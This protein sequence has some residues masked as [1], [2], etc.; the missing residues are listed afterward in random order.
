M[1]PRRAGEQESTQSDRRLHARQSPAQDRLSSIRARDASRAAG[2]RPKPAVRGAAQRRALRPPIGWQQSP[3]DDGRRD[4]R[5]GTACRDRGGVR[6][7]FSGN[8]MRISCWQICQSFCQAQRHDGRGESDPGGA[9]R[10]PEVRRASGAA[11]PGSLS[12]LTPLLCGYIDASSAALSA[13]HTTRAIALKDRRLRTF[14][15]ASCG[16]DRVSVP[17]R[18]A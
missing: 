13:R 11:A 18:F 7:G 3:P 2:S 17:W 9:V 4:S 16:R 1:A 15:S 12:P 5:C 8:A 14:A 10:R 6:S